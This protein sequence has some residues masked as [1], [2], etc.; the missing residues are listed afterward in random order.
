MDMEKE[1]VLHTA[2]TIRQ[3]LVTLTNPN[4]LFSWGIG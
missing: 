1:F 2:E 3:Q 4:I